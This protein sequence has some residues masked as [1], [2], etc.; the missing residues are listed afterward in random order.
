MMPERRERRTRIVPALAFSAALLALALARPARACSAFL[1]QGPAGPVVGKSYD[2]H[3]ERGMAVVNKRGVAKRA[4][5]LSP[6]DAP[7]AWTSRLASLT[8]NQ[9]GRELPNGGMNEAGLV[10]E[11]LILR[12][13][14]PARP[15]GRPVVTELGLVQYLLDQARTTAEAIALA[16]QVRVVTAYAPIHYFVCDA[17]EACAVLEL[18]GG[19]LVATAGDALS[20]PAITN[21]TWAASARALQRR[22]DEPR[23]SLG[24][25][26]RIADALRAPGA[27]APGAAPVA[28]AL[29]LLDAVRFPDSTQ[30]NVV[31][32]PAARRAHFRTRSHPA[33]KT[34]SLEAFPP[35]CGAPVMTFDL[36]SDEAGDVTGRFVPYREAANRALVEGTLA[37]FRGRLPPGIVGRVAAYPSTTTCAP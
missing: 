8:F 18:L 22:A 2:W 30:W 1:Q 6:A 26:V 29:G 12:E 13:T 35:G 11:V 23:S 15:D 3:D 19:E 31:Y 16:R 32:E 7:A 14:R 5:V 25:F 10:V 20:V 28:G 21:S 33:L 9:Y 17:G 36:A 37:P 4:L 24:R 27:R 34:V